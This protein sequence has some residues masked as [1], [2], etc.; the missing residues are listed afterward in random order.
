M[1]IYHMDHM[2]HLEDL[3]CLQIFRNIFFFNT[4]NKSIVLLHSV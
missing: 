3:F 4:A 1:E 2:E